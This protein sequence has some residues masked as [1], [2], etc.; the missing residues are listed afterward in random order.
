MS[1]GT[2][3]VVLRPARAEDVG[4]IAALVSAAYAPY[5]SRMDREPAPLTA[6]YGGLV[7][8]GRVTV[9]VASGEVV[10]VL[11]TVAQQHHLLVD[12]VAVAPET[13]GCGVGRRLLE[14]ADAQARSLGLDELRLYTNAAMTENLRFY[15]RHG[16]RETG[17]H[18][19]EGFDR[20]F[21]TRRLG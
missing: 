16:Y 19:H 5:I 15:P 10:G 11:V 3:R 18:R 8:R 13:Q 7:A 20:V 21:F 14:H 12:N 17:R 1:R 6:N 4:A 9:A 2:D